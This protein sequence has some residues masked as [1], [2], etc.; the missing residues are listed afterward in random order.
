MASSTTRPMATINPPR[1]RMFSVMPCHQRTSSATISESGMETAATR[2]ARALR[3]KRKMTRIA[4]SAPSNPSCTMLPIAVVMGVAWSRML[5]NWTPW[6]T[7]L[8]MSGSA[9]LISLATVTVLASGALSR[10]R[11][12]LGLPLVRVMVSAGTA[13]RAT[14]PRS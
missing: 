1:V 13:T 12:T 11:P 6:P 8:R 4:K 10:L 7:A 5:W 14:V 2:V 9:P 3:R